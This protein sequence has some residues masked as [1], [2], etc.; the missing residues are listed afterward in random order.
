LHISS[1]KEKKPKEFITYKADCFNM[2]HKSLKSSHEANCKP[3]TDQS[4]LVSDDF[5]KYLDETPST[6]DINTNSTIF[7]KHSNTNK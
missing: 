2:Y 1:C 3:C 6:V 4:S 7:G 5:E